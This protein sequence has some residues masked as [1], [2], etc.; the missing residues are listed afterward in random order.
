MNGRR[1]VGKVVPE[2][3][4]VG[5]LFQNSNVNTAKRFHADRTVLSASAPHPLVAS[6]V[7]PKYV[8]DLMHGIGTPA[9]IQDTR[10]FIYRRVVEQEH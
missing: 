6:I 10:I 8:N 3:I 9:K 5:S 4:Y 1:Y 7:E 2:Q